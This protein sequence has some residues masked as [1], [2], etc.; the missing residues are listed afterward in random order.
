MMNI[1]S[2][3]KRKCK[4]LSGQFAGYSPDTFK[5]DQVDEL[6]RQTGHYPAILGCDYACG[7]NNNNNPEYIIDF[8]CNPSLKNHWNQGGFVTVNMHLPN[9]VNSNGGGYKD[10]GNLNFN[11][12]TQPYTETGK[13]WRSFLDR[14]AQGL[15][16][17]NQA[18][19]TV[20]YRPF[21]EMNGDWFYWCAQDPN[22]FKSVWID[23]FNYLTNTKGLHN[24]L[25]VYSPDQSRNNPSMYYPGDNYVDI[26]ALDVYTDEPVRRKKANM[27]GY[28]EM[29]NINKP[30]A[31]GEVGPSTANGQFDYMKWYSIKTLL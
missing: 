19:V 3:N 8:S 10:R 18:G 14:I 24:L 6:A 31:L 30:F 13:R 28:Y 2:L 26:V 15:N 27:N 7:W 16:D 11:D 22:T 5:T 23:M 9:P 1:A 17:L 4:V 25:W 29:T 20:L 12:L 21:H